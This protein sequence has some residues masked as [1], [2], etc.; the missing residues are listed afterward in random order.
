VESIVIPRLDK[1]I[2]GEQ[3]GISKEVEWQGGGTFEYLVMT[4]NKVKIAQ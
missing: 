1:V 3:G 4:E 2:S